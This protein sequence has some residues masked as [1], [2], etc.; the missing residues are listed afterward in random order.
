M[1]V[2]SSRIGFLSL[3]LVL[4]SAHLASCSSGK[5]EDDT[6]L[7][8]T[9]P[10]DGDA[11]KAPDAKS[12]AKADAKSDAKAAPS[13]P[14]AEPAAPQ[15]SDPAS[16]A[17][18]VPASP[19]SAASGSRR[20]MYV[21]SNGTALHDQ[22]DAKSKVVGKLHRGDHILVTIEGDWA[23]TD[24]GKFIQLK[25]L[26]EKGIGHAKTKATWGAEA[27]AETSTPKKSHKKAE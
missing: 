20:V 9:D 8:A 3:A 16:A 13:A 22:A 21:K 26:S 1:I 5:D 4:A 24:D 14:A 7:E 11:E 2:R 12:D 6:S 18:P 10:G 17:I 15:L 19:S 27:P 23:H 25:S